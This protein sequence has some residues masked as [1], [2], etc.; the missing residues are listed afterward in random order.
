MPKYKNGT[1]IHAKG[2]PRVTAGPLR[3]QLVHRIVAAAFIGRDLKKDEEV[4]HRDYNRLNFHWSNLMIMGEKDH[5]YVSAKQAWYMK[6]KDRKEKLAWD[7]FMSEKA[8]E[9]R[10]EVTQAR[11]EGLPWDPSQIDG[12]LEAAWEARRVCQS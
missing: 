11:A 10:T 6:E 9:F 7:A 2:Y 4:H 5:G 12:N 8:E 1:S 3:G